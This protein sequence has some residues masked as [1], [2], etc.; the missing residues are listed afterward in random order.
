MWEYKDLIIYLA[1]FSI[2]AIAAVKVSR[3][4]VKFKLPVITGLLFMGI[5]S[6]PYVI[7]LIPIEAVKRL[8]FINDI[9][10]AYIAFAA[11]TELYFKELRSR[12]KSIVWMTAGQ[13]IIT[14]V[15]GSVGVYLLADYIPFMDGLNS[16]NII[17]V[18]ILT[19]TIFVAR[20]PSSAIAVINEM[21]AKG[22]F[23]QTALGVTVLK[24]VLVIILFTICFALSE[25]LVKGYALEWGFLL[26][27]IGEL[28]LSFALGY[29]ISKIIQGILSLKITQ[30][31]K[32]ILILVAG[33]SVY[34]L[35]HAVH[36]SSAEHLPFA[37]HI[38]PLLICIIGGLLVTNYSQYRLEFAKIL[39]KVG[40]RVYAAFFV[41][42]GAS[43][44]LDILAD[45]WQVGLIFFALRL[46]GLIIGSF[47]GGTLG[48]DPL[49]HSLIGWMPY[50][51]QAG[52]S[53]GLATIIAHAFPE[54][55]HAL[56][57]IIIAVI[58]INQVLGPP[59]FKWAINN[60]KEGHTRAGTP[61][62]DGIRDVI[63][64]GLE[65]K[66]IALARQFIK[67]GWQVK[68]ATKMRNVP[69]EKCPDLDVRYIPKTVDLET[70]KG[71]DAKLAEAVVTCM[72]DDENYEICELVYE[73][74]GTR[75]VVVR[76]NDRVN[77]DKFH[78][79]GAK[80]VD[81]STAIINLLFDFVQSPQA[82]SLL[83][84]MEKDQ[85]TIDLEVMD[86]NLHG[87]SLRNLRLPPD[88]IILSVR[89][90]GQMIISHGYTRLRLHDIVTMVGS[91]ESLD[92][93]RLRFEKG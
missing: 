9:A 80:V 89:R 34:L 11:G 42:I 47:V 71:L 62:F 69:A 67:H 1:G 73:H 20:S 18:A 4:F 65:D 58:V 33:Y 54:W 83:L 63:I 37:V 66:T 51:T 64:F 68:I 88:I 6:G 36:H 72:T 81:P 40:P 3:I 91:Y 85:G 87:I 52:V 19:G 50:V 8:N 55:G 57:T 76:L 12:L 79:L 44:S 86:K 39:H 70:L 93:V 10:L 21:R 56:E 45:V 29:V 14:F 46:A 27:L 84:G 53:L 90:G 59:L 49:K 23:T 60:V 22:P 7:D 17:A 38:E 74:I 31:V 15:L 43:L 26:L 16:K 5:I 77:F 82:T 24:D 41:L 48:G 30:A 92:T 61:T 35:S 78:E 13:L 28:V 75:D 2:V 32:T 25:A